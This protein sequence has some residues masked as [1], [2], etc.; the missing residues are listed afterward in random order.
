VQASHLMAEVQHRAT[1]DSLTNLGNREMF[2]VVG[3]HQLAEAH[4]SGRPLALLSIDLDNFKQV[5]DNEGHATGDLLLKGVS[6]RINKTIRASD[7]AVR[8]GGDEFSVLLVDADADIATTI[9]SRLVE[10]LAQPFEKVKTPTG[11]SIGIAVYPA[12][13]KDL[14]S[15]MEAADRTLYEVKRSG[16]NGFAMTR[17][18]ASTRA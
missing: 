16:R 2:F 5:N 6:E 9:A 7:L 1:H 14:P 11:S 3:E 15:L 10:E 8:M 18:T 13:G 4:R 17:P 12:G